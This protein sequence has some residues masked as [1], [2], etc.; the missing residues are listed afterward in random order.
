MFLVFKGHSRPGS[1]GA[2]GSVKRSTSTFRSIE[3][4]FFQ[5]KKGWEG[6]GCQKYSPLLKSTIY[7]IAMRKRG[8]CLSVVFL[9]LL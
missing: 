4:K 3:I 6:E 1:S 9:L 8:V 2:A 5:H 7:M